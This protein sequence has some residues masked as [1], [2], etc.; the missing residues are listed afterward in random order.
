MQSVLHR[1]LSND[2]R[3]F[4]GL[5]I[6]GCIPIQQQLLN[7]VIQTL[8]TQAGPAGSHTGTTINIHTLRHY[9]KKV[10]V[11][12]ERGTMKVAFHVAIDEVLPAQKS[13]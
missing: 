10:E 3:E 11:I 13:R 8:L 12:P 9:I 4:A 2:L 7:E 6:T 5:S 1:L